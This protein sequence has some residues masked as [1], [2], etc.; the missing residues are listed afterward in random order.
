MAVDGIITTLNELFIYRL[1]ASRPY[2]FVQ[3]ARNR[4]PYTSSTYR[5]IY[6]S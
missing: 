4:L 2:K 6:H 3:P 5:H 1:S